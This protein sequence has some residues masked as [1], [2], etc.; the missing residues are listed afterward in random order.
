M[1]KVQLI[2][3]PYD[4]GHRA[5]RLGR[6]PEVLLEQGLAE[7][8]R[9]RGHDVTV[10][11]I[12]AS[13][14]FRMEIK[15]AFELYR[16]LSERVR[17][18]RQAGRSPLVVAG[19]C[20][21]CLG[22]T[23]GVG[24]EDLG[25]IWFD[26]HGDFNTPE[27]TESGFLDGMGLAVAAGLC[28]STLAATIPG[29][30]PIPHSSIVHV[31]ARDLDPREKALLDESLV[32]VV[33]GEQIRGGGIGQALAP[34]LDALRQRVRRVYLHIDLDVLDPSEC[35]SNPY[36]VPDGLTISQLSEAI[37]MIAERFEVGAAAITAYDPACDPEGRT[38]AL[39]KLLANSII[40]A[41][42][43]STPS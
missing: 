1:S 34:A 8:L 25:I 28:W 20:G 3:V 27:T 17:E 6:G 10:E 18:A 43:N 40:E 7:G 29:F 12:E 2:T 36:A 5:V 16:L 4:S 11:T 38:P 13:D 9:E 14:G 33:D 41:G 23:A 37:G 39:V 24:P 26:A 21:T 35:P 15:T 31:G 19:N 32:T 22:T 30:T 42:A